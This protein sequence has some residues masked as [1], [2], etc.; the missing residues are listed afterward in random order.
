VCYGLC[1]CVIVSDTSVCF[2][3][4]RETSIPHSVDD[5]LPL[6]ALLLFLWVLVVQHKFISS[7][8]RVLEDGFDF[9]GSGVKVPF[10]EKKSSRRRMG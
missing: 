2:E 1:F 9:S 8:K 5:S 6:S 4:L 10:S 7:C 3:R